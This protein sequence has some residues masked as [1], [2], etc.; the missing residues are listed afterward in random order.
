MKTEMKNKKTIKKDIEYY[1]SL[2][3]VIELREIPISDGGGFYACIP[4]FGRYFCFGDGLTES[5]A[6]SNLDITK[7]EIFEDYIAKGI[8]IP[9]PK[10]D[11]LN[12]NEFSGKL[13]LRVPKALHREL[14]EAANHNNCS[15]NQFLNYIITKNLEYHKI[16]SSFKEEMNSISYQFELNLSRKYSSYGYE[17]YE[18]TG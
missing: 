2:K 10:D 4:Q 14:V 15:L 16:I 11:F 17:S 9:D 6:L 18:P 8:K 1:L 3:Y 7:K 13:L 12:E 5:E